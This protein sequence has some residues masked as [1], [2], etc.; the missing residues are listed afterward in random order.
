[1]PSSAMRASESALSTDSATVFMP[2][3]WLMR[4]IE[5]TIAWSMGSFAMSV[6]NTPAILRKSTGRYLR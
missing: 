5:S 6:M 4:L 2:R 3:M 1:M